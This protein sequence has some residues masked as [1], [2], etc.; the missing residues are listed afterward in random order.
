MNAYITIRRL[1]LLVLRCADG[2]AILSCNGGDGCDFFGLG[3]TTGASLLASG[4][5]DNDESLV[6]GGGVV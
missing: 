1:T 4:T 3:W 5:A 2:G 6:G